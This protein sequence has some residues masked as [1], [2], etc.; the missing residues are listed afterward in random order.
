MCERGNLGT[1]GRSCYKLEDSRWDFIV[2]LGSQLERPKAN[3]IIAEHWDTTE[4]ALTSLKDE[5][6]LVI[7]SGS[8]TNGEWKMG[9]QYCEAV[10]HLRLPTT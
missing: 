1:V 10:H 9:L 7:G 6:M 4:Q 3:V 2:G 5:G 8:A